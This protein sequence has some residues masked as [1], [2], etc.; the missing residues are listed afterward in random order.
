MTNG[1]LALVQLQKQQHSWNNAPLCLIA[2]SINYLHNF[3]YNMAWLA[4]VVVTW[5]VLFSSTFDFVQNCTSRKGF[6]EA[7]IWNTTRGLVAISKSCHELWCREIG[8]SILSKDAAATNAISWGNR[9]CCK[10]PQILCVWA[11]QR[12]FGT[13]KPVVSE[14]ILL[15][16]VHQLFWKQALNFAS[17]KTCYNRL[18][19]GL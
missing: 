16:E 6:G 13:W 7:G 14:K 15:F 1:W 17:N 2:W 8:S 10:S 3:Y 18:G 19:R 5:H 9:L 4:G 12:Y 11:C